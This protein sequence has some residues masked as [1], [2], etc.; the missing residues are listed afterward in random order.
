MACRALRHIRKFKTWRVQRALAN[1]QIQNIGSEI[2]TRKGHLGIEKSKVDI[3]LQQLQR[4]LE[5]G[6]LRLRLVR[7]HLR[8]QLVR[9]LLRL[10]P[11]LRRRPLRSALMLVAETA[12]PRRWLPHQIRRL[13]VRLDR[14]RL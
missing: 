9:L 1:A 6:A 14:S 7:A 8:Q 3:Q 12:R 13:S 5:A 10:R 2:E 4:M 11:S